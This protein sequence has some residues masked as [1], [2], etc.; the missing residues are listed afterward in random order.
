[1]GQRLLRKMRLS[2]N[3]QARRFSKPTWWKNGPCLWKWFQTEKSHK[4]KTLMTKTMHLSSVWKSVRETTAKV[5][6]TGPTVMTTTTVLTVTGM[7]AVTRAMRV[8]IV[9]TTIAWQQT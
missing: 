2:L 3:R 4:M 5:T 1:M 6:M 7:P 8:A 9:M